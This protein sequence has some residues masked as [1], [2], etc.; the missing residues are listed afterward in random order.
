MEEEDS[1]EEYWE[2]LPRR[3]PSTFAW[4]PSPSPS[5]DE[6]LF[7][8]ACATAEQET[9]KEVWAFVDSLGPVP[10][11]GDLLGT[12]TSKAVLIFLSQLRANLRKNILAELLTPNLDEPEPNGQLGGVPP[13]E[14]SQ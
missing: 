4:P 5:L 7:Q 12:I 2:L 9:H 14:S 1:Y 13:I 6:V 11:T 8:K 10:V 3:S